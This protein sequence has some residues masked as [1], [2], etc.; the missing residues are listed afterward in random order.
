MRDVTALPRE[1]VGTSQNA[2][3]RQLQ[4][5][6]PRHPVA[7]G[8]YQQRGMVTTMAKGKPHTGQKAPTS[9][10]YKPA[11]GAKE[12]AVSKGDTLPPAKGK[13]TDYKL[14]RPTR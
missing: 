3:R 11:N 6:F 12:I 13:G 9:G 7:S 4:G 14:V 8:S 1:T 5:T 2:R 10:I